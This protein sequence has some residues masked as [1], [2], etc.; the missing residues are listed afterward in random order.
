MKKFVHK[1]ILLILVASFVYSFVIMLCGGYEDI[2]GTI[3]AKS[4]EIESRYKSRRIYTE[5]VF[6]IHPD[7]NRFS[8]FDIKVPLNNYVKFDVGDKVTFRDENI[9]KYLKDPKWYEKEGNL[10]AVSM[11][12]LISSIV[13]FIFILGAFNKEFW[14]EW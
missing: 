12:L 7:D 2:S 13:Y 11:I 5:Y 10:A 4:D 6:A 3:I 9:R 8:D 14:N 1:I